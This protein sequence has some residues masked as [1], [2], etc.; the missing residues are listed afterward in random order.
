[1]IDDGL[2]NYP[3][4]HERHSQPERIKGMWR[5]SGPGLTAEEKQ[6][7]RRGFCPH[8]M[9]G[10]LQNGPRHASLDG[11]KVFNQHK[12]CIVCL[13][14]Y[15]VG[16]VTVEVTHELCPKERLEQ[17]YGI[18]LAEPPGGWPRMETEE[19]WL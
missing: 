17:V 13:R 18:R 1:M 3:Q 8:C 11:A 4:Q 7:L 5:T 2:G 19:V 6:Q 12:L 10:L 15:N 14:E 9:S 16:L